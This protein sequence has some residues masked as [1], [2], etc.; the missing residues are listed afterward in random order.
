MHTSPHHLPP[1]AEFTDLAGLLPLVAHTFPSAESI[2]WFCRINRDKLANAGALIS[3]TGR[4]RYHPERFQQAAAEIGSAAVVQS[5][6][7]E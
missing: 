3:I 2:R 1:L 4:L 6:G 7:S 5:E